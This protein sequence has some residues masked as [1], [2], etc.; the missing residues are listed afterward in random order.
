MTLT[1]SV[2]HSK[3]QHNSPQ[4]GHSSGPR[5]H[6]EVI[7][8]V[9]SVK[10]PDHLELVSAAI[11]A[12]KSV[13]RM[14]RGEDGGRDDPHGGPGAGKPLST[15]AWVCRR[16]SSHVLRY[17]REPD[18]RGS[19]RQRFSPATRSAKRTYRGR[20][21]RSPRNVYTL[22]RRRRNGATLPKSLSSRDRWALIRVERDHGVAALTAQRR[23][24]AQL[25][26]SA[27]ILPMAA[28]DHDGFVVGS[29]KTGGRVIATLRG[30]AER[31]GLDVG[32]QRLRTGI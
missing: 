12:G 24:L 28:D 32:D 31:D 8:V 11:A 7:L 3:L 22:D 19:H 13:L 5:S 29:S 2:R 23:P 18:R 14:G 10:V 20:R 1:T 25:A 9:A 26:G 27:T 15:S 21:V 17:V 30:G 4:G 6:P 16:V